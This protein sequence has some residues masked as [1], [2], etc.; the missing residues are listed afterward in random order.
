MQE[1][2]WSWLPKSARVGLEWLT[3]GFNQNRSVF[4]RLRKL[5][6]GASLNGDD[7][8]INYF[9]WIYRPD[10]M[11]L[12]TEEFHAALGKAREEDPMLAFLAELPSDT[13][14]LERMLALEQRF[15]LA[16][17]NLN[18]TDKMSMAVGVEV[19]VPFLDLDL[20]DFAVRIPARF[21]QRGRQGKWV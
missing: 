16:E 1:V 12:F 3:S 10:L 14:R 11:K 18:Y 7:R 8:L 2:Y 4:R 17:H 9:R 20:V 5:F 6:N 19:R 15:F 13:N 21:K